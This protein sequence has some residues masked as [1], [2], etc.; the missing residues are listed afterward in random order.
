MKIRKRLVGTLLLSVLVFMTSFAGVPSTFPSTIGEKVEE[1]KAEVK[2][3]F[4]YFKRGYT[5]TV[6]DKLPPVP[7]PQIGGSPNVTKEI[8]DGKVVYIMDEETLE[9][10]DYFMEEFGTLINRLIGDSNLLIE[11]NQQL[12]RERN[13]WKGKYQGTV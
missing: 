12:Q 11:E 7:I 5:G 13:Y 1:K 4:K 3:I 6:V 8:R 9:T 2:V 10:F